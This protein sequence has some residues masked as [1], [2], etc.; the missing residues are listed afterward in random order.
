MT[1]DALLEKLRSLHWDAE[2]IRAPH[3]G[4]DVDA[5]HKAADEALLEF[6]DDPEI[7]AAFND[8]DKWYA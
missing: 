6:I 1:R 3:G 2:G 4:R 8:I 5:E 7:T